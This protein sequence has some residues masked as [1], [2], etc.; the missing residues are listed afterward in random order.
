MKR[1]TA[2]LL[3]L[4]LVFLTGCQRSIP[5]E[6]QTNP[7]PLS[8]FSDEDLIEWAKQYNVF[9][10]TGSTWE[11]QVDKLREAIVKFEIDPNDS[12]YLGYSFTEHIY[13]CESVKAAFWSY[14]GLPCL[15]ALSDEDLKA[16]LLQYDIPIPGGVDCY[17]QWEYTIRHTLYAAQFAVGNQTDSCRPHIHQME[18]WLQAAA[19]AYLSGEE[20][21]SM[22]PGQLPSLEEVGT[23]NTNLLEAL[24][25]SVPRHQ[26]LEVWGEPVGLTEEGNEY[27]FVRGE[28]PTYIAICL[29]FDEDSGTVARVG[30][31]FKGYFA[32]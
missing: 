29:I 14:M 5:A 3:A 8:E 12:F 17:G 25:Y 13:F 23:M 2:L 16:F 27:W 26:I 24:L 1:F 4:L 28:T 18:L 30:Y 11:D 21:L 31:L 15:H 6:P 19:T 9:L 20:T 32:E 7:R 22:K 10:Y